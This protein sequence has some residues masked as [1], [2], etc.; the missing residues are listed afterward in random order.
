MV[1]A[2]L[3]KSEQYIQPVRTFLTPQNMRHL[4]VAFTVCGPTALNSRYLNTASFHISL[5]RSKSSSFTEH[6]HAETFPSDASFDQISF[7][8]NYQD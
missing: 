5:M 6:I 7:N 2:R 8:G 3:I 1:F 4:R